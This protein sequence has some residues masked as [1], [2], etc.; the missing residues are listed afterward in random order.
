ML[1]GCRLHGEALTA[2]PSVELCILLEANDLRAS[3]SENTVCSSFQQLF[4]P[5]SSNVPLIVW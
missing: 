1:S 4:N 2:A 3:S 5:D